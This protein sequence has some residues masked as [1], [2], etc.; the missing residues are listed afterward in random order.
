[1]NVVVAMDSFKG[2]LTSLE[3]GQAIREGRAS[4]V[5]LQGLFDNDPEIRAIPLETNRRT[6]FSV[7]WRKDHLLR[8][9]EEAFLRETEAHLRKLE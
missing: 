5:L 3:A 9:E 2:S 4:C 1:M 8:P 7:I 6:H